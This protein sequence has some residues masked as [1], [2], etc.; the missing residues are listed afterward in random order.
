[1][2]SLAHSSCSDRPKLSDF[3][4]ALSAN[5]RH[6][7]HSLSS[8]L[9]DDKTS[10]V[11]SVHRFLSQDFLTYVTDS[12]SLIIFTAE[13][14]VVESSIGRGKKQYA[15]TL[16]NNLHSAKQIS[17]D[18]FTAIEAVAL[19]GLQFAREIQ[20]RSILGERYICCRGYSNWAHSKVGKCKLTCKHITAH[21]RQ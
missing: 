7:G 11:D 8:L 2:I 17:A 9:N 13:T 15:D 1:M 14:I 5:S 19:H 10:S 20:L 4:S 16:H 12:Q 6:M 18:F 3:L 21:R